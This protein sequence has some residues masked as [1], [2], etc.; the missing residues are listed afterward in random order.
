M[1][2]QPVTLWES[3]AGVPDG[4]SLALGRPAA[5]ALVEELIRQGRSDLRLIGVPT[6]GR[7]VEMLIA[8]GCACSLESSGVDLGEEGMAPAFSRAVESGA[9]RMIDST[10]P[11]MLMALQ[12]GASGVSF[13]A[14]PGLLG[15]D[16]L[17]QRPDFRVIDD[18]YRPDQKIVLVPAIAPEFALLHGRRA[19]LDGNVVI[20][21]E[22]D[23]RLVA[24]A[25]RHVIFS[26][27][28]QRE[29]ATRTLAA[30][31]QVVP[32]VLVDAITLVP[33]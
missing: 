24:Q 28:E 29:D 20:G 19:D 26:V 1:A 10:C 15:T 8:A 13:A 30:G 12:A 32:A 23:D 4:A 9:L 21:T 2:V 5:T 27:E 6:G 11:A 3:V 7:A 31:E 17:R 22:F 18:P 25:A 33:R 16:L 14:V